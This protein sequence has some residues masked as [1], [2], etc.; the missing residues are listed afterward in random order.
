MK[1]S[2]EQ[3]IANR[4]SRADRN[5]QAKSNAL[6]ILERCLNMHLMNNEDQKLIMEGTSNAIVIDHNNQSDYTTEGNQNPSKVSPQENKKASRSKHSKSYSTLKSTDSNN[7]ECE[8]CDQGGNMICCDTCSFVFH[9]ECVR[10]KLNAVPRGR[11]CCAYCVLT[12]EDSTDEKKNQSKVAISSMYRLSLGE[13]SDNE[14]IPIDSKTVRFNKTSDMSLIQS[15]KR[16]IVRKTAHKQPVEVGRFYSFDEALMAMQP[17][18]QPDESITS[19]TKNKFD[20]SQKILSDENSEDEDSSDQLWCNCCL[21]DPSITICAFCGCRKCFGKFD[22]DLLIVCDLCERESHTYCMN[23]PLAAVP[24]DDPWYCVDC[25]SS[26]AITKPIDE[27]NR[28]PIKDSIEKNVNN[29][30]AIVKKNDKIIDKKSNRTK[31]DSSIGNDVSTNNN[32]AEHKT[33]SEKKELKSFQLESQSTEVTNN[34]LK[35]NDKVE[36]SYSSN[37]TSKKSNKVKLSELEI[38]HT[39]NKSKEKSSEP[40]V[41]NTVILSQ[42]PRNA[43]VR[44]RGRPPG[45]KRPKIEGMENIIG[46]MQKSQ[47]NAQDTSQLQ[48][49]L[50]MTDIS[51]PSKSAATSTHSSNKTMNEHNNIIGIDT[52]LSIIAKSSRRL[53]TEQET[54]NLAQLRYWAP[55]ND[56]ELAMLALIEQKNIVLARIQ[57][58]EA[59]SSAPS[60]IMQSINENASISV[61]MMEVDHTYDKQQ[62]IEDNHNNVAFFSSLEGIDIDHS[63]TDPLGLIMSVNNNEDSYLHF[64]ELSSNHSRP[65][66]SNN[67]E[68]SPL[69]KAFLIE[70]TFITHDILSSQNLL[71]VHSHS[72][73]SSTYDM[74]S[75]EDLTSNKNEVSDC[76][77]NSEDNNNNKSNNSNN[78]NQPYL[79]RELIGDVVPN[80]DIINEENQEIVELLND[81]LNNND[82]NDDFDNIND[83]ESNDNDRMNVA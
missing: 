80:D 61:C 19:A 53:L 25:S 6:S 28:L 24:E 64:D 48:G 74:V 82:Q 47:L 51:P 22:N 42:N 71:G 77:D 45:S 69:D 20:K 57:Q 26:I 75:K 83:D 21:D 37:L 33:K 40:S 46:K 72:P 35:L 60:S 4:V 50:D 44:G 49:F 41:V 36:R 70:D 2:R 12:S 54:F 52:A 76:D 68:T 39:D 56:L 13:S 38:K 29:D 14:L 81:S 65:A 58:L 32:T 62:I 9:L 66:P 30:D 73:I 67:N 59:S 63:S 43:G 10:P 23:P 34:N 5:I 7:E 55:L 8:V 11:Y 27:A 78:D 3:P 18:K 15:N 31:K 1:R 17:S 16:F 79:Q